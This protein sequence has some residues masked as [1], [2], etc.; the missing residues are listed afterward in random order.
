MTA[1]APTLDNFL[2][3]NHLDFRFH[4]GGHLVASARLPVPPDT[5][6][7]RVSDSEAES[8]ATLLE[9]FRRGELPAISEP[10]ALASQL[11]R[12][13]RQMRNEVLLALHAGS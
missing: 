4:V 12:R 5:G 7:V 10:R 8:L 6:A 9:R 2:L 3:T 11:A 13:T 1:S